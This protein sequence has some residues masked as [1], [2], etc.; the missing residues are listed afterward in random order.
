MKNQ[1]VWKD[2]KNYEGLYQVSNL[3]NVKSLR[4]NK[5]RILKTSLSGIGYH[6]VSLCDVGLVK[7]HKIHKLV[8]IAFLDHTPCG[9]ELVVKVALNILEYVGIIEIIN[10]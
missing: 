8:A 1:E 3:G 2:V 5:E 7:T 10:G 4:F 9:F 6:K